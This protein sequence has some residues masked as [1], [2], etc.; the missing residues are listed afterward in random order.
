[1]Y[2]TFHI[3]KS[4]GKDDRFKDPKK[5]KSKQIPVPGPGHYPLIV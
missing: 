1:M 5:S 4:F 2:P 3:I